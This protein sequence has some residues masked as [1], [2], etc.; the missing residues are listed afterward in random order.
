MANEE[1]KRVWIEEG[2]ISCD[3][4]MDICPEVFDVE[5]SMDCVI[6]PDAHKHFSKKDED[7]RQ[8]CDDCPVE[9]IKHAGE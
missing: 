5:P 2:C 9:V 7:I 4:C 8:A 1:I 6:K 3:L